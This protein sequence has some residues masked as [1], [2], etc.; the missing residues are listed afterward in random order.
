M[1]LALINIFL[2]IT[3]TLAK[4]SLILLL[5]S[6]QANALPLSQTFGEDHKASFVYQDGDV[7]LKLGHKHSHHYHHN[8]SDRHTK[9]IASIFNGHDGVHADHF[10]KIADFNV[11]ALV[12]TSTIEHFNLKMDKVAID[13]N[14]FSQVPR[15]EDH[16]LKIAYDFYR[17]DQDSALREHCVQILV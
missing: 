1:Y 11:D 17:T 7:Y 13:N 12:N 10:I 6:I 4:L 9:E 3:K 14:Y 2:N 5:F 8:D 15:P 16:K